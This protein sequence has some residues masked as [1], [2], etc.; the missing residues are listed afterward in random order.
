MPGASDF[1]LAKQHARRVADFLGVAKGL[2]YLPGAP[3]AY[4]EDSDQFVPFRQRRY[5]YYLTG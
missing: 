4:L 3:T 1:R 5:F 2:I